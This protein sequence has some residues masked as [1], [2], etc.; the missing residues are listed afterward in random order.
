MIRT[1]SSIIKKYGAWFTLHKNGR[2]LPFE[3][4]LQPAFSKSA[5]IADHAGNGTQRGFFL[6]LPATD[7]TEKIA[8]GDK[9]SRN[10]KIYKVSRIERSELSGDTVYHKAVIYLIGEENIV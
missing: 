5:E 2:E 3:G 8:S 10:G 4:V 9:I 1:F 7:L 6:Y